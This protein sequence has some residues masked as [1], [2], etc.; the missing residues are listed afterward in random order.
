[1][2]CYVCILRIHCFLLIWI[3][4][5]VSRAFS[6]FSPVINCYV[7]I[8]LILC[9]LLYWIVTLAS[10]APSIFSCNGLLRQYPA[11]SLFSPVIDCYVSNSYT[12]FYPVIDQYVS[13]S[14][15]LCFLLKSIVTFVSCAFLVFLSY[16]TVMFVASRAIFVCQIPL[17]RKYL[18]HS[19]FSVAFHCY[20]SSISRIL[21]F[22]AVLHCYV[23]ISRIHSF[24]FFNIFSKYLAHSQLPPTIFYLKTFLHSDEL[25]EMQFSC[26]AMQ[27]RGKTVHII[28]NVV[29]I[30]I[31]SPN[32]FGDS[33][34]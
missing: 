9:F 30:M 34:S 27:K 19:Q 16:S 23:R 25:R 18:A 32:F 2:D 1:M 7:G 6:L 33:K 3:V 22:S 4:T 15:T 17:P 14:R 13:I 24:L 20:V 29:Q 8:S 26:N 11:H 28:V 31:K 5:L 12:P 10:R 21:F